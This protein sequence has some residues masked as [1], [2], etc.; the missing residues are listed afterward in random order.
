[1]SLTPRWASV[2]AGL[3]VAAIAGCTQPP[4]PPSPP[5][6]PAPSHASAMKIEVL[7][8]EGC[9]HTPDLLANTQSAAA[10]AGVAV[11]YVDQHHLAEDD[12]RRGYPAPT[13]L[14]DGR[15]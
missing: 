15:D 1:M 10:A 9:P 11:V 2:F 8:F 7:G 13:I 4:P 14:V 5:P 12:L 6:S 3:C